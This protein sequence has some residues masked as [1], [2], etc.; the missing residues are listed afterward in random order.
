MAKKCGTTNDMHNYWELAK[1]IIFDKQL[2]LDLSGLVLEVFEFLEHF[3]SF[4]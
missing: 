1:N 2:T 3:A 4:Q